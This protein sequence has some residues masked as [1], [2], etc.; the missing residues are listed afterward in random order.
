MISSSSGKPVPP[1]AL[2]TALITFCTAW[3]TLLVSGSWITGR[4]GKAA[5]TL[6]VVL[7]TALAAWPGRPPRRSMIRCSTGG[8]GAGARGVGD[9][10]PPP[11]GPLVG[12]LPP[13]LP[14][15]AP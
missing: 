12:P 14:P 5:A 13:V 1:P 11:V 7:R 3:D 4:L 9:W 10:P 2:L 6:F 15:P 8:L